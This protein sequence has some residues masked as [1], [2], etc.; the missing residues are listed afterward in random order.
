MGNCWAVVEAGYLLFSRGIG[1]G[2]DEICSWNPKLILRTSLL[3]NIAQDCCRAELCRK[4]AMGLS[5]TG[6]ANHSPFIALFPG[7]NA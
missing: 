1:M 4:H 6:D 2:R 7:Y 5:G 3:G